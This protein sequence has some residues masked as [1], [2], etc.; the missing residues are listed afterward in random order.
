MEPRTY[1]LEPAELRWL[2]GRRRA[3]SVHEIAV[4]PRS[5]RRR[6]VL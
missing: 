3:W 4:W 5:A 1:R 6:R 2:A